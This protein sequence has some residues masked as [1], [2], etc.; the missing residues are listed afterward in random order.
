MQNYF[1]SGGLAVFDCRNRM[2]CN[3][4]SFHFSSEISLA[5]TG[6]NSVGIVICDIADN[7]CFGTSKYA[8]KYPRQEKL[9][10]NQLT[11][12]V[13]VE[14]NSIVDVS[15]LGAFHTL[16]SSS[17]NRLEISG[18]CCGCPVCGFQIKSVHLLKYILL[19]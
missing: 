9:K 4:S 2:F 3:K 5:Q 18:R 16:S 19:I 7:I 10:P 17:V 12:A 8:H 14:S 6:V 1:S 11:C 15:G 13:L